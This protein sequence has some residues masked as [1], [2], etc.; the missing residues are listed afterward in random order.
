M[1]K[2]AIKE[3]HSIIL[4]SLLSRLSEKN[5]KKE[6]IISMLSLNFIILQSFKSP[7]VSGKI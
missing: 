1:G 4:A 5:D 3:I 2:S 7:Y 6:V